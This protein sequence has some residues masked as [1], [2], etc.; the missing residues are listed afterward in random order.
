MPSPG[1]VRWHADLRGLAVVE[2]PDRDRGSLRQWLHG[3]H[4][5]L[6]PVGLSEPGVVPVDLHPARRQH[7][8]QV[9]R[10]EPFVDSCTDARV[11]VQDA[12]G[13]VVANADPVPQHLVPA[14]AIV[15]EVGIPDATAPPLGDM[16]AGGHRPWKGAGPVGS[17]HRDRQQ[18]QSGT[19]HG[20]AEHWVSLR[21]RP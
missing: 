4:D 6:V 21:L 17:E 13:S 19:Y 9:E 14:V 3:R 15:G 12:G 8:V 16:E 11:P 18:R 1:E 5:E 7:Q 10:A 20:K 2:D